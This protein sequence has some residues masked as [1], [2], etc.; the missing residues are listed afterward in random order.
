MLGD[1]GVATAA[2]GPMEVPLFS[3]PGLTALPAPKFGC[4]EGVGRTVPVGA[5]PGC[6]VCARATGA[7]RAAATP[8]RYIDRV[9]RRSF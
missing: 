1:G 3:A 7:S 8:P 6:V 4:S 9:A 2:L 5:V